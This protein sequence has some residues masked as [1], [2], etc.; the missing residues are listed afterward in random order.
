MLEQSIRRYQNRAIEAAQV[1]EEMIALAKDMRAVQARGETLN[2]T[3]AELAF[4][5]ALA[6][7]A[8]A[9]DVLG[10]SKLRVIA[11]E[12]LETV[13]TN[14]TI[15]WTVKESVRAKLRVMVRRVLRKY[16]YPPDLQDAAIQLILAQ[17][18]HIA[19]DWA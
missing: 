11:H 18:E 19:A 2:M 17:A 13:R 9:R 15:D 14:A 1:I 12:V 5:D 8:S 6:N 16:G 10:D 3:P 4:Y 7:N